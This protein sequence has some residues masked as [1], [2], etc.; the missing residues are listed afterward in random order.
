MEREKCSSLLHPVLLYFPLGCAQI[1]QLIG[2]AV[3]NLGM[4]KNKKQDPFISI[5]QIQKLSKFV[6]KSE[7]TIYLAS[8]NWLSIR[9]WIVIVPN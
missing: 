9:K 8:L 1:Y 3:K 4:K 2:R 6:K 7:W 5:S